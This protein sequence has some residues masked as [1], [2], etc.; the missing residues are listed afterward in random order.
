[1]RYLD[2]AVI[3]MVH[4]LREPGTGALSKL[5]PKPYVKPYDTVRGA[6]WEGNALYPG[7]GFKEKNHVQICVR[8]TD[9]IKGYFRVLD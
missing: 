4:K 7:A 3:E 1:M 8:D 6:F 2:C 5:H 9:C